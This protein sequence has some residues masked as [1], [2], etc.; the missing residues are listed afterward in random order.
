MDRV[1]LCE[2]AEASRI[3]V[4]DTSSQFEARFG[5]VAGHDLISAS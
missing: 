4:R 3:V 2:A 5:G 1:R